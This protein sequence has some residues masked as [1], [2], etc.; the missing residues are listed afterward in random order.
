MPSN[1]EWGTAK[2]ITVK[3][4]SALGCETKIIR[5]WFR[6]SCHGKNDSGGTP[7]DVTITKGGGRGDTFVFATGDVSSLVFPWVDGTSLEAVFSWTDKSHKLVVEWPHGSPEPT[8]KGVF[9]GASSPLD[10]KEQPGDGVCDCDFKLNGTTFCEPS[11]WGDHAAAC[12]T[13]YS[14]N[15]KNMLRCA[16]GDPSTPP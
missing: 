3:G 7:T 15:C 5:E 11:M 6:V 14:G 13:K 9:E 8:I 12:E 16:A 4:S 2:E 1:A 10:H